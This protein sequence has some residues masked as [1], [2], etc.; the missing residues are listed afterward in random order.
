MATRRKSLFIFENIKREQLFA[1][2]NSNFQT[3]VSK[4]WWQDVHHINVKHFDSL[5][6]LED[7]L[8]AAKSS[9]TKWNA[10]TAADAMAAHAPAQS[11]ASIEHDIFT[12]GFPVDD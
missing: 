2:K 9:G 4:D 11:S 6:E 3:L 5:D 1:S 8:A 7:A 12:D 10:V